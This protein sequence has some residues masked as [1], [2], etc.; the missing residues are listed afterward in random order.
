MASLVAAS[1]L[2]TFMGVEFASGSKELAQAELVLELA[3]GAARTLARKVWA[4]IEDIAEPR[5]TNVRGIILAAARRELK[6]PQRIVYEVHGPDA[7]SRNQ[8]AV[9]PGFFTVEEE[10]YLVGCRGTGSWWVMSTYRDDP[11]MSA[12]YI[13][14]TTTSKP[15]PF[16]APG[17]TAGWENADKL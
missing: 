10:K 14:S 15:I 5:K 8:A 9:P 6:N 3:S 17:D 7:A 12:G 13:R 1:E 4:S 11:E 16:Y 2:A